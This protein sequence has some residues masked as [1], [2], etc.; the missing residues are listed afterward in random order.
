[1]TEE[2]ISFEV[3]KNSE[4]S[5]SYVYTINDRKRDLFGSSLHD[6]KRKVLDKG[7]PWDDKKYPD[8]KIS[9]SDYDSMKSSIGKSKT[10]SYLYGDETYDFEQSQTLRKWNPSSRKWSR[11]KEI[12]FRYSQ[13][14]KKE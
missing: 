4:F 6:L 7:L 11:K 13:G 10:S 8:E 12:D 14:L 1:M 9:K 2:D 3:I 5:W